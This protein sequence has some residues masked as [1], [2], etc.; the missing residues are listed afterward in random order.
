MGF[1][2]VLN[3]E[4]GKKKPVVQSDPLSLDAVR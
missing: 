1:I 2:K 4:G 3:L